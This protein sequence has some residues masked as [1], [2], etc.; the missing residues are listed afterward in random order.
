MNIPETQKGVFLFSLDTELGWG[1][2][3]LDEER[4]REISL[5][6][7]RE[8][9]AIQRLLNLCNEFGIVTTWAITGH[10]FYARCEECQICPVLEWKGK[11]CS[12]EQIYQTAH[13]LWYGADIVELL[14]ANRHQHEIAFHGYTHRLF[15]QLSEEDARIEIQEWLRIGGRQGIVPA[16]IVFPRNAIGHL[17]LFKEAGFICYRGNETLPRLYQMGLFGKLL[18]NIDYTLALTTPPVYKVTGIEPCGLVNLPASQ[19][20]FGYHGGWEKV[21]DALNLHLLRIRRMIKGVSK[22]AAEKS[23]FHLWAHPWEFQEEKD[24]IKLRHL[25][26]YVAEEIRKDRIRSVGMAQLASEIRASQ[27]NVE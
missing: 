4:E 13:P 17:E 27:G 19:Y 12:F 16:S 14:A 1:H 26:S 5:D 8:R 25:L 23:I 3:D 2:F 24:F 11:Y 10:M 22:A 18:K 7:S 6:G 9:K 20:F 21:L 15:D